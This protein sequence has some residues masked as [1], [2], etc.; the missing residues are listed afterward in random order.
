MSAAGFLSYP[1][2]VLLLKKSHS[3]PKR[4]RNNCFTK[5]VLFPIYFM[6]SEHDLQMVKEFSGIENINVVPIQ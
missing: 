3:Y 4:V 6:D 2:H 1:L 5:A